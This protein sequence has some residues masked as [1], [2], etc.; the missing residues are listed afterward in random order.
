MVCIRDSGKLGK[1]IS[2]IPATLIHAGE[3]AIDVADGVGH[4]PKR[5]GLVRGPT[6]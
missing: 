2:I 4:A 6:R 3:V 1:G 5:G